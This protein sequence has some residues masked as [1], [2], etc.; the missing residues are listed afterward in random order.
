ME[1]LFEGA[2]ADKLF[3]KM[4]NDETPIIKFFNTHERV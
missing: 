2:D 3:I 4:I 1:E